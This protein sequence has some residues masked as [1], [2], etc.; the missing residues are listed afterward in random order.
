MDIKHDEIGPEKVLMVYDPKTGMKGF[1]V[2]DNTKLGPAKGGI[3][4]TPT[5]S[6]EE[7]AKLARAM[8]LKNALAELPFG[9]G[10]SGI[11][12]DASKIDQKQKDELMKAF[13]KAIRPLCP[14]MY[15]A[16]PDISTGEHEME[17]F[18]KA[19]G[20]INA[21]TGKPTNV[22]DGYKCGIPHELGS[23]G[24]GVAQA[25]KTA[26]E[27]SGLD[28]SKLTFTVDGYGNVGS[29]TARFL[30]Q[31]GAKFVAVSDIKG[32][33]YDAEGIDYKDIDILKSLGKSVVDHDKGR[34]I[35]HAELFELDVDM[36][37]P[38][39]IPD[40]INEK[41][42][43]KV[44]AKIIVEGANIPMKPEIE[45]KLHSRGVLIVPDIIANSGG[46]I[47]SYIEA[48]GGQID[49]V[50]PTIDKKIIPNTR[51]VLQ[52]SRELKMSTRKAAE[53]IAEE[54]LKK[55]RRFID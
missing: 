33:I 22:C 23:T 43:D 48:S 14:S 2:I 6:V 53:D 26:I 15:I 11:V 55:A 46:V 3:R 36:L 34:K 50:F 10:K 1:T 45:E 31:M 27:H 24:Y 17:I 51:L 7:V 37:I 39:S 42:V 21:C 25:A 32:G 4:M 54:R 41:N 38:A 16:A 40:V 29:F 5:V 13:G 28:I 9:G 20:D 8:T 44:K 35:S 12:A 30:S 47:S 19:V 49:D 18:A 52:R